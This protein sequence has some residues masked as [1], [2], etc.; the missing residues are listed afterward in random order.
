METSKPF[1]DLL[2]GLITSL[3]PTGHLRLAT[4]IARQL[5]ANQQQHIK[6]KQAPDGTPYVPMKTQKL[7]K[8]IGRVKRGMFAKI[9]TNRF[10]K[11]SGDPNQ[12]YSE[13][14]SPGTADCADES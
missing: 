14:Y 11:A 4:A 2:A 8:K 9:R 10:L 5:R 7:L 12:G 1:D 6:R 13:V 3:S